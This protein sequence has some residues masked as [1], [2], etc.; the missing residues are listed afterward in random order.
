MCRGILW[1][2]ANRFGVVESRLCRNQTSCF[3]QLGAEMSECGLADLLFKP[4]H[5][6]QENIGDS[7]PK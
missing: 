6:N 5:V 7:K 2:E 3:P 4:A 1:I